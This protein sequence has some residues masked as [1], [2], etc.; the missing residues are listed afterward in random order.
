[1][2]AALAALRRNVNRCIA[3]GAPVYVEQLQL[4]Q[5]EQ[6]DQKARDMLAYQNAM[7]AAACLAKMP[8]CRGGECG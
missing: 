1:M 3:E 8:L 6:V 5:V 7:F 4:Q 2:N